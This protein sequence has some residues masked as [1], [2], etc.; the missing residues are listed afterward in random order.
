MYT[1]LMFADKSGTYCTAFFYSRFSRLTPI[2]PCGANCYSY[3]RTYV[4]RV[5]LLTAV[6]LHVCVAA[7]CFTRTA[8]VPASTGLDEQ[9]HANARKAKAHPGIHHLSRVSTSTHVYAYTSNE[10]VLVRMI[11]KI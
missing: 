1:I 10:Y 5:P 9:R 7:S 2:L 6:L 3:I 11:R 8:T 4:V